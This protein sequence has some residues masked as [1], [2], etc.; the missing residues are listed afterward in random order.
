M[1]HLG[2]EKFIQAIKGSKI[3][4]MD[5]RFLARETVEQS[6]VCQQ[7]NAYAA[8]S[9]Q[10]KISRGEQSGVYWE[11]NFTEVKP[12]KYVYKYLLLFL[13]TSS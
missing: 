6:K 10:G 4:V 11:V 3:Y 12:G 13:D 1:T 9:K 5:L 8:K 7:I 2:D